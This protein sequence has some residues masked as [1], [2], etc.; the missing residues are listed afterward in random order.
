MKIKLLFRKYF[1]VFSTVLL[2]VA[3]LT[4]DVF[5]IPATFRPWVF[6]TFVFWSFLFCTGQFS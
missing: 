3:T 4:P 2:G 6:V 5:R 1:G